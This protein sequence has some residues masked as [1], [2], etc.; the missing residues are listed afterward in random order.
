[1][2]RSKAAKSIL[3]N[4]LIGIL[5]GFFMSAC[6]GGSGTSAKSGTAGLTEEEKHRLYAAALG[7]SEVPLESETFTKVCRK[8]GVFDDHGNQNDKYLEFV[9]AHLEWAMKPETRA[10]K[11][12]IDTREKAGDYINK[13]LP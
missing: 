9:S 4:V 3:A 5:I 6:S 7:A 12:E 11:R 1:M 10:F 13:H 2:Q 8:I